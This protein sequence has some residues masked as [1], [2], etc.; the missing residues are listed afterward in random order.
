MDRIPDGA[1]VQA[2]NLLVPQLTNRTSVSLYGWADSRPDPQW[3]MVDTLVPFNQRWPLN[4]LQ[5]Q[6]AL[7]IARAQGYLTV[8]KEQGFVLLKRP[9]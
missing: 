2:S 6:Q 7:G 1:T 3:I 4:V 9:S 8:G 5:E